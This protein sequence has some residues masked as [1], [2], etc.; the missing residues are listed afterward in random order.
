VDFWSTNDAMEHA[1]M[2]GL[3]IEHEGREIEGLWEHDHE[4]RTVLVSTVNGCK[5]APTRGSPPEFVAK[6]LLR[7]LAAEGKV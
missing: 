2:K 7:E 4:A 5:S 3:R 6:V 1:Q